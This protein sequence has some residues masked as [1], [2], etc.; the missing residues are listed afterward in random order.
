MPFEAITNLFWV[1]FVVYWLIAAARSKR[2]VYRQPLLRTLTI[3]A[4]FWIGAALLFMGRLPAG[5][6]A[7]QLLPKNAAI[8]VL[9]TI[10]SGAGLALAIWA[11]RTLGENW[12]F[13]VTLKERHEL[14]RHGPY[15]LIRHPIYGGV[16]LLVLGTAM[17]LG[18]VR[19]FAA[20]LSFIVSIALRI[21]DEEKT[22][23]RQFPQEYAA[24][25]KRT[26]MLIPWIF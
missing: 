26:K 4:G 19:G 18:E 24:Y 11:R 8:G 5:P 15:R 13:V 23:A 6:L 1:V 10:L 14:I 2:D 16:L 17:V 21:R 9:G 20:L 22:L 7:L 3:S 25:R 12:S